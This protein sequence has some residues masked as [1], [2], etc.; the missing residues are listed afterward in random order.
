MNKSILLSICDAIPVLWHKVTIKTLEM[1][2]RQLWSYSL[3]FFKGEI[4]DDQFESDFITAIENQ[5]TRAW[6][7]GA[8]EVGVLPEEMTEEDLGVLQGLID[9]EVGYLTGLGVD[10]I[11]IKK[12]TEGM[13]EKEA[14]DEFRSRFR[15]R[16]DIWA[17]KYNEMVNRA[18]IHFGNK[19]KLRWD[20]GATEK[21][22]ETCLA[23]NGIVA[24]AYEWEQSGI[25]PGE[26]GSAI[27]A[28][29]GWSCDCKLSETDE[30]RSPNAF[31]RLLDIATM[32][33]V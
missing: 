31:Q 5:L 22:C 2:D 1:F 33:N 20:L 14:L 3:E 25:R 24:Y 15:N 6:N 12:S 8:D 32:G 4:S 17:S 9:E 28:C 16:I 21:H 27:L 29:G 7:E 18:K 30:R 13:S 10:I 11:D 26:S 23:L 19:T